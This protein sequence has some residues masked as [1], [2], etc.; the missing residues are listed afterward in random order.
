MLF[1]RKDI[2]AILFPVIFE[3]LLSYLIGLMDSV[4]VASAGEAAV[5][6]VSLVDSISVLFINVFAALANGGAVVCGQYLGRRS[7]KDAGKAAEQMVVLLLTSSLLISGVLLA[8][9]GQILNFLFGS[10]EAA[11]KENCAIYYHIVMMSIPFIA[12]YNGGAALFR[13][14]GDSSTPLRVSMIMNAINIGGNALLIYGFRMGVAGVAIPTLV[15]RGIAMVII[16]IPL[17]RKTSPMNISGLR[18]YRLNKRLLGSILAIGIPNGVENG[19]FQFGKLIL[20][21]LISTLSTA[22]ITAN[23][24]GNTTGSLHCVVGMAANS[25]LMAVVS[26]CAGAGDFTQARWYTRYLIRKTYILQ[27]L[28]NLALVAV[29]PLILRMYGAS[30]EV[31]SFA[32]PIM[33]IHG[34]SSLFLWPPAFMLN[35]SMRSAGDS[36][37]AMWI[38]SISMWLCRVGGAYVL[39][40][41]FHMDVIG[42]WVAWDIDWVFRILFFV[43]R[44]IGHKWETKTIADTT[45]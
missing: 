23:A 39:V 35:I 18:S 30:P 12:L 22:S 14:T 25:A 16:L 33:L 3:T 10:A 20:M 6:A 19:M 26:R 1:S 11:V 45:E 41:L 27:G 31:A 29:I 36:R 43:P 8:F 21:T 13:T 40:K 9:Q 37:Y 28:V 4:M 15:S 44:Y 32:I 5:S 17:F 38:S 42:V 34:L 2:N 24:I 7:V